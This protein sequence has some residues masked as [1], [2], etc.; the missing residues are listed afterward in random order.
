MLTIMACL[1]RF[2]YV[3][4]PTEMIFDRV[5]PLVTVKFFIGSL[6]RAGSYSALMLQ[7]F[8]GRVGRSVGARR[9]WVGW[10]TRGLSAVIRRGVGGWS[11]RE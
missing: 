3:A 1:R 10:C 11:Y 4:T 8:Y 2:F 6:V 9:E 5:F 7:G